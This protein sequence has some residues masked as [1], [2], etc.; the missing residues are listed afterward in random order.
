MGMNFHQWDTRESDGELPSAR[1]YKKPRTPRRKMGLVGCNGISCRQ[2]HHETPYPARGGFRP[3]STPYGA[4]SKRGRGCCTRVHLHA[5]SGRL[6]AAQRVERV[7]ERHH[8]DVWGERVGHERSRPA[9][10]RKERKWRETKTEG[11]KGEE[12]QRSA[13]WQAVNRGC[14]DFTLDVNLSS[15]TR[16][17][18]RT[19]GRP[20]KPTPRTTTDTLYSVA[21]TESNRVEIPAP[22]S[23]KTRCLREQPSETTGERECATPRHHGPYNWKVPH[24][25]EPDTCTLAFENL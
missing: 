6:Q 21:K 22:V 14:L 3:K 12:R 5:I 7:V 16:S 18:S 15:S 2:N 24:R 23:R 10:F 25:D 19:V 13:G 8:H 20:P 1:F 11:R 4:C 9:W 17:E